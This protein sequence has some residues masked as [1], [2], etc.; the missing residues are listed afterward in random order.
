MRTETSSS[1]SLMIHSHWTAASRPELIQ[2]PGVVEAIVAAGALVA[3]V[4]QS[5]E[6]ALS[7]AGT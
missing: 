3:T 7:T 5:I 4:R 6:L 1:K 2:R